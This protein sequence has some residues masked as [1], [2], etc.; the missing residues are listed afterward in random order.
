MAEERDSAEPRFWGEN[1]P[2]DEMWTSAME[3]LNI[4][5]EDEQNDEDYDDHDQE[6]NSQEDHTQQPPPR[7]W[8]VDDTW[9]ED[10]P[11]SQ[12]RNAA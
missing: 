6:D 9:N 12:S 5:E 4:H 10:D 11:W 2:D 8:R 3:R 1:G 7:R